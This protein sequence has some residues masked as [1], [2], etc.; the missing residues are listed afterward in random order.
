[1][2]FDLHALDTLVSQTITVPQFGG[3]QKVLS[4]DTERWTVLFGVVI[5]ATRT[6]QFTAG[7]SQAIVLTAGHPLPQGQTRWERWHHGDL[8]TGDI[9]VSGDS[10]T[11]LTI[12]SSRFQDG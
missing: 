9:W 1:M 7:P 12:T 10:S 5:L 4:A 3:P 8:V 6:T 2:S 11:T